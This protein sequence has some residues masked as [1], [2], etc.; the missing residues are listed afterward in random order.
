MTG[1]EWTVRLVFRVGRNTFKQEELNRRLGI[2]PLDDTPDVEAYGSRDRVQVA[3]R[4]GPWQEVT[5]Q[6]H[7]LSEIDT[8]AFR[9]FLKEAVRSFHARVKRAQTRP[10]DLM[11]WKVNGQRWHLG[12]KGFPPGRKIHWDRGVL[13]RLL[14]LVRQVEPGLEVRWEG[15]LSISRKVPGVS[16]AWA[17]WVTKN[18]GGLDCRF[19]G[20][21]GQLNLSRVEGIG[22]AQEV[23]GHRTDG[24]VL[25]LVFRHEEHVQ[26]ARLKEVL[27][28]LL[29]GFRE[30]FGKRA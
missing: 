25:R 22:A 7:R 19:L 12:E 4:K 10:E 6:A 13:P 20:K 15:R 18:P 23:N 21:R 29:R 5:V 16:R 3:N 27:A 30:A 14:D 2:P 24:D 17:T 1:Q 28:E 11:P 9:E 8:P 26:P